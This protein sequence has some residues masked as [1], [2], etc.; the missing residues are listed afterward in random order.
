M[1]YSCTNTSKYRQ[2]LTL[3]AIK[4]RFAVFRRFFKHVKSWFAR[5]LARLFYRIVDPQIESEIAAQDAYIQMQQKRR[6]EI[7]NHLVRYLGPKI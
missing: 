2:S 1:A 5:T 3:L 4:G 6:K 7:E